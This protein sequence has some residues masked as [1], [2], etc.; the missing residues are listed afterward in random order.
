MEEVVNISGG[1]FW[2][3]VFGV[4][5]LGLGMVRCFVFGVLGLEFFEQVGCGG[6]K[7]WGGINDSAVRRPPLLVGEVVVL[8]SF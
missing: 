7:V 5:V 8:A 4:W 3:V 6:V 1:E 2:V